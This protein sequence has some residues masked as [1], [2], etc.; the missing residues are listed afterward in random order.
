MTFMTHDLSFLIL[1]DSL[2]ESLTPKVVFDSYFGV[3]QK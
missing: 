2:L 1:V 3:M